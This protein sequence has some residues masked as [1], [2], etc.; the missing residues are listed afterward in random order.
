MTGTGKIVWTWIA[1]VA[2]ATAWAATSG[3]SGVAAPYEIT[4]AANRQQSIT[5]AK[6]PDGVDAL[7]IAWGTHGIGAGSFKRIPPAALP[8]CWNIQIVCNLYLPASSGLKSFNLRVEDASGETFQ[9]FHFVPR[10][11]TGWIAITN[12]VDVAN[13]P[14]NDSWGGNGDHIM[15]L[16]LA[17][18]GAGFEFHRSPA[19]G[20]CYFASVDYV[21]REDPAAKTQIDLADG[22]LPVALLLAE[23]RKQTHAL[24]TLPD[25]KRAL[26]IDW[27][28]GEAKYDLMFSGGIPLDRFGAA[29]FRAKVY[30]PE[31]GML[32]TMTLRLQDR[33]GE[34]LQY[35]QAIPQNAA[36][37]YDVVFPV[38]GGM[39]ASSSWGGS[40]TNGR[41][42][43]PVD[44]GAL[45]G[46]F[47]Q[48]DAKGW[49]AIEA[50]ELDALPNPLDPQFE[51][52]NP[53]GVLRPGEEG[54]LGW[55]L[56]N[57]KTAPV[58][59]T[60]QYHVEDI[61]GATAASNTVPVSVEPGSDVFVQLPVPAKRGIYYA[62]MRYQ[63]EGIG[64]PSR[65]TRRSFAYMKPVGP[66]PGRGRGFIFGVCSHSQWKPVEEQKRQALAA[67]WCGVKLLRE[68]TLWERMEPSPEKWNFRFFDSVVETFG[69]HGI[70][71]AP[72]YCYRPDWAV[73]KDWKPLKPESPR[74]KR[75][76][77]GHWANFVR[78]VAT[79]YRDNVRYVEVWNEPDLL[80][81]ANFTAEEY[82]EMMK[83]AY[84]E[85]KRAA[86]GITVLTGGFTMMPPFLNINDPKHME[87]TLVQGKGHY[88]VQAFHV[89]G[90]FEG[91]RDNVDR[92]LEFRKG[93]GI[94]SPWWANETAITSMGVGEYVQAVT[95]FQ[96]FIYTWA[97]GAMG[98]NW[99]SL[100]NAG[101]DPWNG[102][103]NFGLLTRDFQP[104]AAYPVYNTL[105]SYL[106]EAA[107]VRD[108][109]LGCG[110]DAFLFK[111]RNGDYLLAN[112]NNDPN[113]PTRPGV[114]KGI[115]GSV[116]AVDMFG[117]ENPLPSSDNAVV[118]GVGLEPS[119]VRIANQAAEPA[120]GLPPVEFPSRQ[121]V[122]PG[123]ANA[124]RFVV[125][126][127]MDKAMTAK[128]TLQLPSGVG[129]DGTTL[130]CFLKPNET[131][132]VEFPLVVAAD[133]QSIGKMRS[134]IGVHVELGNRW[135]ETFVCKV[136]S[137]V[138]IPDRGFSDEPSFVIDDVS[139]HARLVPD[140]P[141]LVHLRWAGVSD[142]S[143]KVWLAHNGD[144]L[145]LKA[146]VVDDQHR[147]PHSGGDV[148]KS[149]GIQVA[150]QPPGANDFWEIGLT[151]KD[152]GTSEV[153]AWLAPEG[154]STHDAART[155]ALETLRDESAKT[156]T[157]KA[158]F[159][160]AAF[161]LQPAAASARDFGFNILVNDDDD[162]VREGFIEFA[163]G[164]GMT[165]DTDCFPRAKFA[166]VGP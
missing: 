139:Q 152:N 24:S 108:L 11:R 84:R 151:R 63:E 101:N 136:N 165:K 91:Y 116:F 50:V 52:G 153:Y 95:L 161:G 158:S 110:I 82:I 121:T 34:T 1:F 57:S 125:R 32:K 44:L 30:L 115:T 104:K 13:P 155:V 25:G 21:P 47:T 70:E 72:I 49:M 2:C 107:Y 124:M 45:A 22:K 145:L 86:P 10:G 39:R 69:K 105:A 74:G 76:D 80:G 26:R 31:R 77:Y 157:Y 126:N 138:T 102:E 79:R 132:T 135:E 98:Y 122:I 17:I 36:G 9:F 94:Q 113:V 7:K 156:T 90:T 12:L 93:L 99:F 71:V 43:F 88:D 40:D 134:E 106:T 64:S 143:A 154:F 97:R 66:T 67:A 111:A 119:L 18:S 4:E 55:R 166:P 96:K 117:N 62:S 142:L 19:G 137:A 150:I 163:P 33:D 3:L 23:A 123:G 141:D 68:D 5:Q 109:K 28:G 48:P 149:D 35:E 59:A 73:A 133:F 42:D 78:E 147:Q 160:L 6:T 60:L 100:C 120:G 144:N 159:P 27:T 87:K 65:K 162:G 41:I 92:L 38:N 118:F 164:L 83:I 131:A 37:W 15:D 46:V 29:L 75:P 130:G 85:T 89:H 54:K 14:R 20:S 8:L 56:V 129:T 146:V 81:Y 127:P 51:T 58:S 140:A 16:P 103:H 114:L 112:W 148:F 53:I 128:I 61:H